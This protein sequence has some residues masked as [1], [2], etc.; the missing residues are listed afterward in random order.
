M[1]SAAILLSACALLAGCSSD[2]SP[3]PVEPSSAAPPRSVTLAGIADAQKA[4]GADGGR[5]TVP[6]G[7]TAL[8]LSTSCTR[9]DKSVRRP[10]VTFVIDTGAAGAGD[11]VLTNVAT[12]G[13]G[14]TVGISADL[15]PDAPSTLTYRVTP[16]DPLGISWTLSVAA[17]P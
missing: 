9:M 7:T 4:Y 6:P 11:D 2:P 17:G 15:P 1:R 8:T 13:S 16:S 14:D 3:D 5:F 10:R 12:C